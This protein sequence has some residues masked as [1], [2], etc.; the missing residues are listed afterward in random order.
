VS[1]G[2]LGSFS[3]DGIAAFLR[4]SQFLRHLG[5]SKG[6]ASVR[7]LLDIARGH[8]DALVTAIRTSILRHQ[9]CSRGSKIF[10]YDV[11]TASRLSFSSLTLVA[12]LPDILE[13]DSKPDRG[14]EPKR[15]DVI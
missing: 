3:F 7:A 12:L 8:I 6:L 4:G 9:L 1:G 10:T 13:R 11:R 2:G 14:M 15:R 5:S